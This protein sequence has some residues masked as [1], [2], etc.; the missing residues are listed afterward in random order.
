MK[1][2]K[3]DEDRIREKYITIYEQQKS[4]IKRLKAK[5]SE[6][7]DLQKENASLKSDHRRINDKNMQLQKDS[8]ELRMRFLDAMTQVTQLEEKVKKMR[9]D[10]ADGD[11]A[12]NA[13]LTNLKVKYE[14]LGKKYDSLKDKYEDVKRKNALLKAES[15]EQPRQKRRRRTVNPTLERIAEEDTSCSESSQIQ[16]NTADFNK[17]NASCSEEERRKSAASKFG[18]ETPPSSVATQMTEEKHSASDSESSSDESPSKRI[19]I[20]AEINAILKQH[21]TTQSPSKLDTSFNDFPYECINCDACFKELSEL[22]S[23]KRTCKVPIIYDSDEK[24]AKQEENIAE[25]TDYCVA[26]Y[27]NGCARIFVDKDKYEAHKRIHEKDAK[28]Q[29]MLKIW[30][31]RLPTN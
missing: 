22:T 26:C 27:F 15:S 29:G 16:A 7:E 25:A 5:L 1:K 28:I 30:N 20:K 24:H 9:V 14:K 21:V 11:E 23:H 10:K 13:E 12:K 3:K 4:E 17:D 8:T 31:E 19:Q 18:Y 2:T 6:M